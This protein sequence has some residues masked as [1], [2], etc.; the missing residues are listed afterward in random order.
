[1]KNS[2]K[3]CSPNTSTIDHNDSA[4]A[5]ATTFGLL[6]HGQTQWNALKKIQ[7]SG[8]SPLTA[9]GREETELW[10]QT[11]KRYQWQRILASD[12]GR[13]QE[14]VAILN[15][16]LHLPVTFD[17]RLREQGWGEW[18][19]LTIPAIEENFRQELARRVALGWNFSA[20]GGETRQAVKERSLTALVDAAAKWPGQRILVVCHQGVVKSVLYHIANREFLPGEDP[21]MH[22]DRFHIISLSGNRFTPVT[23]NIPRTIEP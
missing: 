22:H 15:Q 11:L 14:T 12:L 16:G 8:D 3:T 23:L 7:G 20:P 17:S 2:D 13:V 19:G 18:E 10:L 21:L 6:R 1:M 4:T 5:S 9:T